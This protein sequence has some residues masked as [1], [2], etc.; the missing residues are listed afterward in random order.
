MD[1]D[2]LFEG[3]GHRGSRGH[4]GDDHHDHGDH[5]RHHDGHEQWPGTYAGDHGH[6]ADRRG[7]GSHGHRAHRSIHA[8]AG[9]QRL[10]RG[11]AARIAAAIVAVVGVALVAAV[12][13]GVVGYVRAHG[14]R[15]V[16]EAVVS[17]ART[18]WQGGGGGAP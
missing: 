16:V 11:R 6:G 9:L 1:L 3:R 7:H 4:H 12:G 13:W 10:L 8:S 18:V 5:D 17:V 14:V 2:D 15:G